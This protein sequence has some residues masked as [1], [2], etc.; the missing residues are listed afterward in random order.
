MLTKH[1][2]LL[3]K[4]LYFYRKPK[5]IKMNMNLIIRDKT[6]DNL[7]SIICEIVISKP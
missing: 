1:L 3:F 4:D 2:M 6:Y 5:S 7:I